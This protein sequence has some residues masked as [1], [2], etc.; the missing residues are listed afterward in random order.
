M[1][2]RAVLFDIDGTLIRTGGAGTKAFARTS[3]LIYGIPGGTAQMQFHGRTDTSLVREFFQIHGLR[4]TK[5]DIERFLAAYLHLLHA[6]LSRFCGE[7]CPGV[8]E[9][10]QGLRALPD[11]P[12]IGLLTGNIQAGA[13]LKLAAHQ[14]DDEF[15][16]GAFGDEHHVRNELAVIALKKLRR[17]FGRALKAEEIVVIGDTQADIECAHHI[18]ARCVATATGGVSLQDLLA[19]SP[20]WAVESL[21]ELSPARIAAAGV[22]WERET[23]WEALYQSGDTRWDKGEPAPGLV[24][25]L[26]QR[27]DLRKA[28][29]R[30]LVPGCG[31]GHDVRAWANAGLHTVGL[32]LSP[33]AVM[34]ATRLHGIAGLEFRC[35]DFL[36]WRPAAS[37]QWLFEHTLFCAIP[38][39]QRSAYVQAV[40]RCLDPG[41]YFF[42]IHYL[43]PNDDYG[44]PHGSTVKEVLGAFSATFELLDHWVP[45]SFPGRVGRERCFLWRKR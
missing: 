11:P 24:D 31:R 41:G 25:F 7:L 32:D 5:A 19:H 12:L 1:T 28:S 18:G 4:S 37:F 15:V 30:V 20:E 9:C 40:V 2:T 42:A 13:A 14:L 23:E 21:A 6:E 44:P 22:P 3:E 8:R 10:I 35:A 17:H 16:L 38:P 36:E 45:R 27:S 29:D 39:S 34:E 33:T 43:Q 26:Y